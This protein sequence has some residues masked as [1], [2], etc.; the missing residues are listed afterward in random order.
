MN[1]ND[2]LKAQAGALKLHGLLS[3][4]DE[5]IPEQTPWLAQLVSAVYPLYLHWCKAHVYRV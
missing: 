2:T 5:L 1:E 4:W 3:H